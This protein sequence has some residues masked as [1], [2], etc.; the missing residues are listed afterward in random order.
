MVSLQLCAKMFVRGVYTSD[1]LYNPKTLPKEMGFR[2]GKTE[3]FEQSY[4][5]YTMNAFLNP[6]ILAYKKDLESLDHENKENSELE[7]NNTKTFSIS[8][9]D[10]N[11]NTLKKSIL[12]KS[13]S[14]LSTKD[15]R[16]TISE[17]KAKPFSTSLVASSKSVSSI[18]NDSRA[19]RLTGKYV[20]DTKRSA[21]I[22]EDEHED[23]EQEEKVPISREVKD[24]I[25]DIDEEQTEKI[26]AKNIKF[27]S[28][29][30]TLE[31]NPIMALTHFQG[32]QSQGKNLL[33][34]DDN[35]IVYSCGN[36]ICLMDFKSKLQRFF[37]GQKDC[38]R[39][40]GLHVKQN[41]LV[42]VDDSEKNSKIYLWTLY[43]QTLRTS[44]FSGMSDIKCCDLAI[45]IENQR[46]I[47]ML[48]I[49]GKDQLKRDVIT[50]YDITDFSYKEPY[51]FCKK[52]SDF[53]IRCARFLNKNDATQFVSCGK[54]SIRFWRLKHKV[55]SGTSLVLNEHGRDTV[56]NDFCIFDYEDIVN[57]PQEAETR[58]NY[59]VMFSS[60]RG[61]VY[62]VDYKEETLFGV[63][64]LHDGGITSLKM[65]PTNHYFITAGEDK[66]VRLW[67]MDVTQMLLE[68]KVD[69]QVNHLILN[70]RDEVDY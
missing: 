36:T 44:F 64:K 26:I 70:S 37:I 63:F 20:N 13:Q 60:N 10:P 35:S 52:I 18:A 22:E 11:A 33:L 65:N 17:P 24:E 19:E 12:K 1:N 53:D 46:K 40:L 67:N 32:F 49:V 57:I 38:V 58:H 69:S 50:L 25:E 39:C 34:V 62:M 27:K 2:L 31:P 61:N 48:L 3:V 55:V 21:I 47:L 66:M 59:K 54:E 51:A 4:N 30:F 45:K 42:S 68:I 16:S 28:G 14:H 15:K 9:K 7:A 41:V 5:W 6:A 56:F 43:P 23:E 8:A 29:H